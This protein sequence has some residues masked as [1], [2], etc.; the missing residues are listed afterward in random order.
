M[1]GNIKIESTEIR[2]YRDRKYRDRGQKDAYRMYR[3]G[4]KYEINDCISFNSSAFR[5]CEG[6]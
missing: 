5:H 4:S 6:L 1:I 2:E 3:G